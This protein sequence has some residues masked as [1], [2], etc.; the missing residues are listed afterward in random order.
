V[1]GVDDGGAA[2]AA[3]VGQEGHQ[4]GAAQDVQVDGDLVQ[5]QDLCWVSGAGGQSSCVLRH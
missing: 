1:G 5:Q 4:V 2:L 3:L